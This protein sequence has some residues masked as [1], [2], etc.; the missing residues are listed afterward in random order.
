[1]AGGTGG[2]DMLCLPITRGSGN[3]ASPSTRNSGPT[4]RVEL[5]RSGQSVRPALY[6]NI[7]YREDK[8]FVVS[9]VWK[10][11]GNISMSHF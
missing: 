6:C 3:Q 5:L 8:Q 11:S 4:T 2:S 9:F 7:C 10:A 1:M